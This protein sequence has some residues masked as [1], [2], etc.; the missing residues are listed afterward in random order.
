MQLKHDPESVFEQVA[1]GKMQ[2]MAHVCSEVM[3][4]PE[5]HEVHPAAEHSAQFAE[6]G[7]Q[8]VPET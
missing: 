3:K 6:H 4:N 7:L 5:E 2:F 8:T 1:H